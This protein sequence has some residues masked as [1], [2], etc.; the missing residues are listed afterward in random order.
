MRQ[1]RLPSCNDGFLFAAPELLLGESCSEKVDLYSLGVLL[2]ELVTQVREACETPGALTACLYLPAQQVQCSG[3]TA[4]Q[5]RNVCGS[6]AP[7][8]QPR[9]FS[10]KS[11]SCRGTA[12]DPPKGASAGA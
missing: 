3:V 9:F 10:M 7:A 11:P 8:W 2:W 12:G 4:W 6:S 5:E 1:T